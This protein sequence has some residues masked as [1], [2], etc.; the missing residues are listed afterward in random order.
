ME[1]GFGP[2]TI[3]AL[4][5]GANATPRR[6]G[7]IQDFS[8]DVS[9]SVKE[10]FGQYQFPLLV[11]RGTM[12]I[13]G[14]IK[15]AQI[16]AKAFNDVYFGQTVVGGTVSTA[17]DEARTVPGSSTYTLTATHAT[18][19]LTDLGVTY[20]TTGLPLTKGATATAKGVY[21]VDAT[22]GIYTFHSGDASAAVKLNYDYTTPVTNTATDESHP[23]GTTPY[24]VT[25]TYAATFVANVSVK[26]NDVAA[27][28]VMS[29]TPTAGQYSVDETTGIYTF[30]AADSAYNAKLTYTYTS[31]ATTGSTL[32]VLNQLL[33]TTP[34]F[35]L[36]FAQTTD[37]KQHT[38]TFPKCT[39]TKLSMATKLED[40]TIPEMDVS[41]FC[42]DSGEIFTISTA[43]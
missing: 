33:G 32:Q 23:I 2:G 26:I 42:D 15:A 14:K 24:K 3:Y 4:P 25:S 9:A 16:S 10:L 37:G 31:A 22:T 43:E 17:I 18:G 13:T 36:V 30:A 34:V 35:Q 40:F 41:M 7:A 39:S 6:I 27:N 19:F 21:C 11:Q 20:A 1:F 8:M 29:G 5:S 28:R 38:I 12:K